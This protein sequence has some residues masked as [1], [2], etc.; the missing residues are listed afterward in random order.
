MIEMRKYTAGPSQ[1][2]GWW[3]VATP[4]FDQTVNPISTSGAYYAHHS[5]PSPL[6]FSD[7]AMDLQYIVKL[8]T[9]AGKLL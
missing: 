8:E 9:L 4:V 5:N 3:A 2:G 7:L 6:R 1:A